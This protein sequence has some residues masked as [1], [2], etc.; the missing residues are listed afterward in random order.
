MLVG[1]KQ[2]GPV[3]LSPDS[4]SLSHNKAIFG[5]NHKIRFISLDKNTNIIIE[6]QTQNQNG[7][8]ALGWTLINIFNYANKTLNSG[9]F[10]LPLYEQPTR[11]ELS[12]S[13]IK[14]TLVPT[15][16]YVL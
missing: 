2:F 9:L 7:T 8:T 14:S 12:L 3:L 10:K 5:R 15:T 4:N 1:N 16:A 11:P 13:Q 6:L